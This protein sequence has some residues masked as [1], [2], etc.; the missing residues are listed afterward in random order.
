MPAGTFRGMVDG[1]V[2]LADLDAIIGTTEVALFPVAAYAGF[3]PN[4]LRAGQKWKLTAFGKMTNAGAAGNITITPRIGTSTGGIALGASAATALVNSATNE[5]WMLEYHLTIRSIGKPG[6]NS[7]CVGYGHF[8]ADVAAIAAST[9]NVVVMGSSA[10]V[11]FDASIS[12][13]IFIG[14]TLGHASD[15]MTV[16]DVIL[17]SYN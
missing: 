15:T 4:F 1:S 17:E 9:G 2:C 5:P 10:E 12:Q 11:S 14:I 13:G 3:G 7:K 8:T 6:A 16:M